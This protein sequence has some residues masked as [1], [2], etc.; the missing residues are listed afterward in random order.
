MWQVAYRAALVLGFRRRNL[1]SLLT[2]FLVASIIVWLKS[3]PEAASR[4]RL[5]SSRRAKESTDD[6]SVADAEVASC[7]CVQQ[8]LLLLSR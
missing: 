8:G 4:S 3:Q 2:L 5:K 7:R 6:I 1:A